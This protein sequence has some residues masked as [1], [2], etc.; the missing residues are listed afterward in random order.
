MIRTDEKLSLNIPRFVM[1]PPTPFSGLGLRAGTWKFEYESL[2][3]DQIWKSI[4]SDGRPHYCATTFPDFAQMSILELGPS[5]G[6][7]TAGLEHFGA[8]R[9]TAIE[10]NSDAFIKACMLK[11]ALGL[12]AQ[13]QLGD[14]ME[15]LSRDGQK[16]DLVYASGVLYHL[17]DPLEFLRLCTTVG[18]HLFLW[19]F[20]YDDEAIRNHEYERR[21]FSG[22]ETFRHGSLEVTGHRRLYDEELVAKPKYQG[23]ID[24]SAFWLSHDDIRKALAA[25]GYTI[26]KEIPDAYNRI[27]TSIFFGDE[28]DSTGRNWHEDKLGDSPEIDGLDPLRVTFDVKGTLRRLMDVAKIALGDDMPEPPDAELLLLLR[29]LLAT[30]GRAMPAEL[31]LQDH[32]VVDAGAL[33]EICEQFH[34]GS[35]HRPPH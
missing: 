15:Y 6:Y 28:V 3:L 7:N 5:D 9:I 33:L 24:Q 30:V 19:T 14:F 29:A 17:T 20:I 1:G 18:D 26:L 35:Y 23:G 22:T 21:L 27:S 10:A 16:V 8:R 4:L 2:S 32:R 11:N 13:F 31:Q 25:F 12:S 34:A